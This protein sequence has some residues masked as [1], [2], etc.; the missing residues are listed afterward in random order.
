MADR[1]ERERGRAP[2]HGL[3]AHKWNALQMPDSTGKFIRGRRTLE[4]DPERPLF[5]NSASETKDFRLRNSPKTGFP[6]RSLGCNVKCEMSSV[7]RQM[8]LPN[9]RLT[10]LI[11]SA[12]N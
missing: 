4:I 7:K 8:Y 11:S 9:D 6:D 5:K 12:G 3:C 1:F 10:Q 2:G